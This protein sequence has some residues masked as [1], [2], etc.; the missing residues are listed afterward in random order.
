[1]FPGK[2]DSIYIDSQ[3]N[4]YIQSINDNNLT[5]LNVYNWEKIQMLNASFY[6]KILLYNQ[7]EFLVEGYQNKSDFSIM[8]ITLPMISVAASEVVNNTY[9]VSIPC[10][11]SINNLTI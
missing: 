11:D 9:T 10:N 3:D 2:I 6:G 7:R 5:F 8:Y 1:M 4:V